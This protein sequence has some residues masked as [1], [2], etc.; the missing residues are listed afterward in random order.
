MGIEP[1]GGKFSPQVWTEHRVVGDTAG[2]LVEM[3]AVPEFNLAGAAAAAQVGESPPDLPGSGETT[4]LGAK[5]VGGA[6]TTEPS[7]VMMP[8]PMSDPAMLV[9]VGDTVIVRFADNNRVRRFQPSQHANDP[10]GGVVH[11]GQP[12]GMALLGI[13]EEDEV[14]L[15]VGGQARRVMVEKISKA[16]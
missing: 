8:Q 13:A 5:V 2:H 4:R 15:L 1:V 3:L 6:A 16:A 9:E 11:I 7:T 12:I 14:G 10:D